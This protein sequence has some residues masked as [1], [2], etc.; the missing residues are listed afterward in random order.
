MTALIAAADERGAIGKDGHIPWDIP[1]DRHRFKELT[2]GHT[3]IMGR[4]TFEEIGR[5][6]PQ[7]Q[8][9]I[10]SSTLGYN[11]G[12]DVVESLAEAVACADDS[13]VFVIGGSRL[14][15]EAVPIA[16]IIYLTRVS[17]D[18]QGDVFFPVIP[19]DEF[20]LVSEERFSGDIPYSFQT[21]MR[22]S[23]ADID[24]DVNE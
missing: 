1:E 6:L 4:R 5:P 24:I 9:I 22:K 16:D 12:C 19:R 2:I 17:G 20:E 10:V 3:V 21:F 23:S 15:R 13:E 18:F 7:R 8:N 11:D 14:F